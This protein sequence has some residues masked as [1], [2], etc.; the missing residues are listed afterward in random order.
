MMKTLHICTGREKMKIAVISV[1]SAG[2]KIAERLEHYFSIDLYSKKNNCMFNLKHIAEMVMSKYR[3][4]AFISSTGIA[5]RAIAPF[6]KAKD[7][8]PAVIVIDSSCK[9][10][11]SLLSGHLGGANELAIKAAEILKATP[12]ITTAT[13][14]MGIKA[15]D[16]LA[17][18]K[19]LVID[20]LED[21]KYIAALL[22]DGKKVGFIDED[23]LI[24]IPKGYS[25]G[26][27]NVQGIV[28]VTSKNKLNVDNVRILKLIRKDIVLGIGCRKNFKPSD[29]IDKIK[30]LLGNYNIDERSVKYIATVEIKS[31]E[32]A[33]IE[34][35]KYFKCS[36]KIF[37]IEQIR[38]VQDN[39][40]GSDFVEKSVGVRAVCQPCVKLAGAA[41]ITD[42]I[43]ADGMTLCIGKLNEK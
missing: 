10:V 22:V 11:I 29:M 36:L 2:D 8:D 39:Y 26:L 23:N 6:I 13:D 38:N 4:I 3:G 42:K 31:E 7:K 41:L 14:N 43:K 20:S 33:I 37:S 17:R 9:F 1:T 16:V 35:A 25:C 21:A 5:V 40:E 32:K 30:K 18:E 28:Y 19:E 27:D 24:D 15:P 12:V 34:L